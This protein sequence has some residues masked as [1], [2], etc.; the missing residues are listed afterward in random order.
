[1]RVVQINV[2]AKNRSTGR[3]TDE[4][5]NYLINNGHSSFVAYG[6]GPKENDSSF[7]KI[8]NKFD[9]YSHNILSRLFGTQGFHSKHSTKKLI[10]WLEEIKPDVVHLRNL[11]SNYLNL[12]LLF[13]FLKKND[14]SVVITTHDFWFLTAF[15][16]YPKKEC[17]ILRCDSCKIF[18]RKTRLFYNPKSIFLRKRNLFLGLNHFSIQANS[19]FSK[20]I[21]QES[22][23]KNINT[24]VIYNWIDFRN[25]YPDSI[26][27]FFNTKKPVVLTVWS[28]L[29]DKQERF[30]FFIK[31]A[32]MLN[33][34]YTFVMLGNYTFDASK[35]PFVSF[36]QGTNNV[37][38][39]RHFYSSADLLFNP[40][41]TDTFWK[42]VA[43]AMSCGTPCIVFNNQAL[44]ELVGNN[45]CGMIVEPFDVDGTIVTIKEVLKNTKTYYTEKCL[46]RSR[47]LFDLQKN[48]EQLVHLY[49]KTIYGK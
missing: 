10:R 21:V 11:H 40:S 49:E 3:T 24:E 39:L 42:V 34:L 23:L 5:H 38:D 20:A 1:M 14:I 33:N 36:Y 35:Y 8:G 28:F 44:P 41:T 19:K 7:Y 22:Y 32:K 37:E 25:F 47:E 48:C 9:Y 27:D 18:R 29:D 46:I 4:L 31:I 43:E 12:D 13:K 30:Q 16:P 2:L 17:D 15:C 26:P 6:I 45:E